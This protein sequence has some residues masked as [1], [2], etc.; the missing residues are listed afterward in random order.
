MALILIVSCIL[1]L[2]AFVG[3]AHAQDAQTVNTLMGVG[4]G[5]GGVGGVTGIASLIQSNRAGKTVDGL[6][7]QVNELFSKINRL[8]ESSVAHKSEKD[9][10]VQKFDEFRTEMRSE[11]REMSHKIDGLQ[12]RHN[13]MMLDIARHLPHYAPR[14]QEP[15]L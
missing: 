5:A 10:M 4:G 9:A 13:T 8:S 3:A 14:H 12:D 2:S 1:M 6:Q 11:V 15:D 7:S